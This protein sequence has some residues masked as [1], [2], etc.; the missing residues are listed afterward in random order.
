L[1][2]RFRIS[3]EPLQA[4]RLGRQDTCRCQAAWKLDKY[5][6]MKEIGRVLKPGGALGIYDIMRTGEGAV[7][8]PFPWASDAKSSSLSSPGTYKNTVTAAGFKVVSKV[9]RGDFVLGFFKQIKAAAATAQAPPP[10]GLHILMGEGAR[11]KYGNMVR[12]VMDGMIAPFE[13]VAQK[14]QPY[15]L[16]YE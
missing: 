11:T 2:E 12:G 4:G 7:V 10:L 15:F 3:G 1:H 13:L 9:D 5:G 6:L 16:I 14:V 8:Y